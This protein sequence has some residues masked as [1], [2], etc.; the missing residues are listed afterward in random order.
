M[1]QLKFK[2]FLVLAVLT[3][4]AVNHIKCDQTEI[5]NDDLRLKIMNKIVKSYLKNKTRPLRYTRG[6]EIK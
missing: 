3:I 6:Y 1:R 4:I 5:L 2:I